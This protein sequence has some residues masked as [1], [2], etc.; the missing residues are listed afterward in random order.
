[1]L[2]TRRENVT[3]F[4]IT[5]EAMLEDF[6]LQPGESFGLS[7]PTIVE[8]YWNRPVEVDHTVED[9]DILDVGGSET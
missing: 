7:D 8:R 1:M 9:G 5:P 6:N 4:G 3:R 2:V